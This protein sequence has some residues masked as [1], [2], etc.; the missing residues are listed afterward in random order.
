MIIDFHQLFTDSPVL[1]VFTVIAVGLMIGRIKIGS[2]E[3]G[4]TTGVFLTGLLF[5]HL[6]FVSNPLMGTFGFSIF[7]FAVG[8]Q[9]GPTFFSVFLTDGKT[10]PSHRVCRSFWKS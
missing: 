3:L 10:Q 7:I 8:L 4:S 2:I 1:M 6:G 5:G 9:A